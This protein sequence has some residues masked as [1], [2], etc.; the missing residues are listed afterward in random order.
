MKDCRVH[1]EVMSSYL[2][3]AASPAERA[4]LEAHLVL[5]P[6]C[7]AALEELR[8]TTRQI[9]GLEPVE[10]PPWMAAKIMAR[11]REDVAPSASIWRR[12]L[13]PVLA[14]A[15]FR[16]ASLVLVGAAGYYIASRSTVV[17][18]D[19]REARQAP[20]AR[21]RAAPDQKAF[22][23]PPPARP[24]P[25]KEKKKDAE[26]A[27]APG[28]ASAPGRDERKGVPP[29]SVNSAPSATNS[30]MA[31]TAASADFAAPAASE[32]AG[33]AAPAVAGVP[34]VAAAPALRLSQAAPAPAAA[35]GSLR[36]REAVKAERSAPDDAVRRLF[37]RID[38]FDGSGFGP[39]VESELRRA[40]ADA[41]TPP[42]RTDGRSMTARLDSRRLPELLDRLER[43]GSVRERPES[44]E[45]LPSV[46]T[47]TIRW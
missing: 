32:A 20:E 27:P 38:P 22:A 9:R 23:P 39:V 4:A 35:S 19:V 47:L 3:G 46:V 12:Y 17:P 14:S 41:V 26:P 21:E 33:A 7:P 44:L 15:Q 30:A 18:P 25:Q 36:A 8:W 24:A 5:C 6:E 13:F 11:L 10:P 29:P 37:I 45:D 28:A 40:G 31:P 16:V 1:R 34:P 2:D 43:I 42:V